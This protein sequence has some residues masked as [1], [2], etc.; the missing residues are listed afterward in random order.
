MKR[1]LVAVLPLVLVLSC[2]T[3]GQSPDVEETTAQPDRAATRPPVPDSM[4]GLAPGTAFEQPEQKPIAFNQVDPGESTPLARPNAEFP[5]AISHSV[6][7][8]D[9]ITLS[10]NS[11]LEC[12]DAAV[13]EDVGATAVPASHLVDL[14]RSPGTA[15]EQVVGSRWVCTSCHV[16]QTDS[17][18]LVAVSARP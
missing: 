1:L 15:E 14:R 4:I 7:D 6:E 12:H 18:P 13:A 10:E 9:T 5:P 16:A 3:G 2:S 17:E 11:C 8:L